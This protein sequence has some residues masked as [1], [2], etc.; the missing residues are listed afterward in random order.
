[1]SKEIAAYEMKTVYENSQK[2]VFLEKRRFRTIKNFDYF[3]SP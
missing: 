2:K 3:E 1:M